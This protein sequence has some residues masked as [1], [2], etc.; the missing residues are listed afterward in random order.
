MNSLGSII[1]ICFAA[2]NSI[3]LLLALLGLT[4][5]QI[6]F[7]FRSATF[8]FI[9]KKSLLHPYKLRKFSRKFRRISLSIQRFFA[10][11]NREHLERTIKNLFVWHFLLV[12]AATATLLFLLLISDLTNK[13][14]VAHSADYLPY[15][16]RITALWAGSSGS[17][18][19]WY[20]LLSLFTCVAIR[21]KIGEGRLCSF[22]FILSASQSL[23]ILL[24]LFFDSAQAF[25][26]YPLEMLAGTGI[27]P[28]LLHWAMIIHPPIL[29]I[30]Y[31]SSLIS[32]AIVLSVFISGKFQSDYHKLLQRWSLF[33]W[34]F[35]GTGIL[36][37]SKWAYEELG[38]GGYWA[39][40]PVENASLMPWLLITAFIHSFLVEKKR[41]ILKFWNAILVIAFYHMCLLGT[42]I[43]RSGILEGPHTFAESDI[44]VPIIIFLGG[45]VFFSC[46]YLYFRRRQMRPKEK[47]KALS[48][49]EGTMLLNNFLMVGSMLIILIGVF[50]P[51]LPLECDL[52]SFQCTKIEWKPSAYNR[53]LIPVGLFTL[54]IMGAAPL[55]SWR[56]PLGNILLSSNRLRMPF[57]VFVLTLIGFSST[58]GLIFDRGNAVTTTWSSIY[59]SDIFAIFCIA[60]CVGGVAGILQELYLGIRSRRIR[61]KT[62]ESGLRSILHMF[63]NSQTRSR[64]GGYVVHVAIFF[65]CIG[66][67][68]NAF[69]YSTTIEF[70]F[71]KA[72]HDKSKKVRY[73][74]KDKVYV[75]NYI[76][77]AKELVFQPLELYEKSTDAKIKQKQQKQKKSKINDIPDTS[78][79]STLG[80]A[81]VLHLNLQSTNNPDYYYNLQTR[82][83]FYPRINPIRGEVQRDR[84]L[85]ALY[86][87]TSKPSIFSKYWKEDVYLQVGTIYDPTSEKNIN[88]NFNYE[89]YVTEYSQHP[90]AHQLLFPPTLI[91]YVDVWINPLVKFIWFG[92]LL[93]ILSGFVTWLP[94]STFDT[95][96]QSR[97]GAKLQ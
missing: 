58:Y 6:S 18:L 87:P 13:Y 57:A 90:L 25:R 27:N 28:L 16:F 43:T 9:F 45:S 79:P 44:G 48:S 38:W 63:L 78:K 21:Q 32:F 69:K 64:Y 22:A 37:G 39:W 2:C 72:Q 1:I 84:N 42:W 81:H 47:I 30:G 93:F 5:N 50:S 7:F 24:F 23:F 35:L 8:E 33:S 86:T 94:I 66:Y 56:K 73:I 20:M 14:V 85:A 51:I 62:E 36:L 19:F 53:L 34:F 59:V 29:Y 12:V 46:R 88:L 68:G 95:K 52:L 67:A 60:C 4:Q 11:E 77:Q 75:K 71:E 10:F 40:D 82:R 76:L 49:K 54:L 80:I 15:F 97:N 83:H 74:A 89:L 92:T 17:L 61:F 26:I 41:G 70:I 55:L 96:R 3:I 65:L 31:V 91:A